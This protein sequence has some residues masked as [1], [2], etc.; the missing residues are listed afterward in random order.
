YS[1]VCVCDVCETGLQL[2][3]CDSSG[4]ALYRSTPTVE[5][6]ENV[7][8]MD[9]RTERVGFA[10]RPFDH[11]LL[12]MTY[13]AGFAHGMLIICDATGRALAELRLGSPQ[14]H[15][16]ILSS[17]TGLLHAALID[18]TGTRWSASWMNQR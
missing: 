7:G 5:C 1:L 18:H 16:H 15:V 12:A 11:D 6:H 14:P 8:I 13:P 3:C 10:I 4:V 9:G 17:P 2:S